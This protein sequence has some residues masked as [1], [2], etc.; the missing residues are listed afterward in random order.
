MMNDEIKTLKDLNANGLLIRD[1]RPEDELFI[2]N[3]WMYGFRQG[4]EY[5]RLIEK[6]AYF[7]ATIK[8]INK[9]LERPNVTCRVLCLKDSEDIIIGYSVTETRP[10]QQILHWI[11]VKPGSDLPDSGWRSNGLARM[12]V[13]KPITHVTHLTKAGR[14]I[15]KKHPEIKFNPYLL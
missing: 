6:K 4:C 2:V 8:V 5:I 1:Y 12:L 15:L 3:S 14:S 7:D 13:D 11:Y 9:I 10:S